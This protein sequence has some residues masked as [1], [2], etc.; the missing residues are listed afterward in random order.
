MPGIVDIHHATA[1]L[2][3]PSATIEPHAGVGGGTPAP[4]KL[5]VDSSRITIPTSKLAKIINVFTTPGNMWT[6]NIRGVEA[7][8]TLASAT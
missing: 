2:S 1:S 7:P 5:N 8:A 3:R 4:R 6:N